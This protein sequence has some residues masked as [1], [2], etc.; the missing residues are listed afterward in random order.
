MENRVQGEWVAWIAI[1]LVT[2]VI[3]VAVGGGRKRGQGVGLRLFEAGK[4]MSLLL[5][6]SIQEVITRIWKWLR[7]WLLSRLRA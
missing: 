1:R 2:V 7:G 4:K 5:R 6:I 3:A